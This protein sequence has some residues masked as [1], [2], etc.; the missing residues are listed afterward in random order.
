MNRVEIGSRSS[1]VRRLA[2][3]GLLTAVAVAGSTLSFPAFGS[4][5]APVQH[6]VNIFCAVFLGPAWGVGSAF[7][8]SLLRNLLSLG[9]PLAFPGSM[10]GALLCG[11]IYKKTKS[12]LPTLV[13]EVFGTGVLGGIAAYPF[14]LL[15]M[16][17][18]ASDIAVYT[19]IV[20]FLVSTAGGAIIAGVVLYTLK[21]AGA[22]DKLR[23]MLNR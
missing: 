11:L 4:S 3:A 21:G 22:L 1:N 19:Y 2:V 6:I 20:P 9:S 7:C 16:N 18:S 12:L 10:L 17:K 23:A 8:S 13:G 15:F 5:C 14:A